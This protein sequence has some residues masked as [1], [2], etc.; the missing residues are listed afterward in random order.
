MECPACKNKVG[1]VFGTCIHCGYN[2]YDNSYRWIEV[3][4]EVLERYIPPYVLQSLIQRH[5]QRQHY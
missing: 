4:M 2:H 3:D 5:K 1:F